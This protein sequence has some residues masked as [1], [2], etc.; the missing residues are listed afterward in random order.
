MTRKWAK[1]IAAAIAFGF[2]LEIP[3]A[4]GIMSEAAAFGR[5]AGGFHGG[6]F[7]GGGGGFH[8]FGGGGFHGFSGGGFRG[9]GG[10]FHGLGG[11]F[12]GFGGG[13]HGFR[14]FGG[15]H[16]F[17]GFGHIG[18]F[19]GGHFGHFGHYGHYGHYGHFGHY[20]HYGR[21][22]HYGHYGHLG[23]HYAGHFGGGRH[24]AGRH[25]E[26]R[27]FAGGHFHGHGFAH[28]GAA[29][30][31][32]NALG[33]RGASHVHGG[34]GFENR[35][36]GGNAFGSAAAWN[37]W[38][39][40]YWG[41]GWDDWSDGWGY[42]AYGVYWPFL[43]GDVLTYV[44]WPYDYYDPFFAY[45]FDALLA[46]VFWPG[47]LSGP[48]IGAEPNFWDVY[49]EAPG[50]EQ[51]GFVSRYHEGRHRHHRL[52]AASPVTPAA[53]VAADCGGLAPGVANLPIDQIEKAV[54]PTEAQVTLL[55]DLRSAL[56]QADNVL[57]ASCVTEV[58]LTPVGRLDAMTKRIEAM[59][60][61]VQ[62]IREPLA[63]FYDALDPQ[64]KERFA[65]I[66]AARRAAAGQASSAKELHG[67]CGRQ[68]ENFTTPPVQRIEETIKP[69]EQQQSA[70]DELKKV[71]T[72]AA[73]D[74][75]ASCPAEPAKSVTERLDMVAKRLDALANALAMV[76]PALS[77]FYNSLTDEQKAQFNVIGNGAP[78]A[79][80]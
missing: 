57:R 63:K 35:G 24:A 54:R 33:A 14:G 53:T 25:L 62:M 8:G 26:G 59:K 10:G 51:R 11:G 46:S 20:G 75:E 70:L 7:R 60:N 5:G 17:G 12:H 50:A 73:K 13:F 19:H 38:G 2:A 37:G 44:L 65:A 16:G 27:H 36:F 66:G 40:N 18:G 34:Q 68:T 56:A 58:P 43:Y 1:A 39:G 80:S 76:K 52:H 69:T 74:L 3:L 67:L 30:L 32:H 31:A 47:P 77:D 22:G 79:H 23:R 61:A 64:Q 28:A 48:Y 45:G 41:G 55:N 29:A 49:G 42:W 72:A 9:F 21:Y 78:R 4:P 6:G 71:S 15:F